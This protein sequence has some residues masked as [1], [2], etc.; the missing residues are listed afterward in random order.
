MKEFSQWLIR[1]EGHCN[2]LCSGSSD[3]KGRLLNTPVDPGCASAS[4]AAR[5]ILLWCLCSELGHLDW[6][7]CMHEYSSMV[8]VSQNIVI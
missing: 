5:L 2:L 8:V 3:L 1:L 7:D 6:F 4:K